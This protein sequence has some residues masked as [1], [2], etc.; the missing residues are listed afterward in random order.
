[1]GVGPSPSPEFIPLALDM[2]DPEAGGSS[3][4][5]SQEPWLVYR[6]VMGAEGL[7][8]A[9]RCLP[10]WPNAYL[11]HPLILSLSLSQDRLGRARSP[12][13]LTSPNRAPNLSKNCCGPGP[14][15]HQCGRHQKLITPIP[16]WPRVRYRRP[17]LKT[18]SEHP[19]TDY[20][21]DTSEGERVM[22]PIGSL[23]RPERKVAT[24]ER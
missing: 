2:E 23:P 17:G 15:G 22:Y 7:V 6:R 24:L 19:S 9:R 18:L 14:R 21:K 12:R 5:S 3:G 20:R 1:M 13:D 10:S 4:P 16:A 11:T 8:T